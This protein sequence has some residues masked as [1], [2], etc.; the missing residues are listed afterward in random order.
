M[1]KSSQSV[2]DRNRALA[3]QINAEARTNPNSPYAG[4]FVGI[5]NGQVV[6]VAEDADQVIRELLKVEPDP[7]KLFC[8]EAGLDYNKVQEIWGVASCLA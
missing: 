4:K 1:S 2:A 7:Q 3:D 5:A 8:L 6:I